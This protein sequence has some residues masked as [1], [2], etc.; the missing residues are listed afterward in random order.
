MTIT[1]RVKTPMPLTDFVRALSSEFRKVSSERQDY[2]RSLDSRFSSN[3][4]D[5][6]ECDRNGIITY[7]ENVMIQ[8]D[9]PAGEY[10]IKVSG[11]RKCSFIW[12]VIVGTI[13]CGLVPLFVFLPAYMGFNPEKIAMG[14]VARFNWRYPNETMK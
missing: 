5:V 1:K 6:Y 14:A 2:A 13:T 8:R 11:I 12:I 4:W 7:H 9:E 3:G 10:V